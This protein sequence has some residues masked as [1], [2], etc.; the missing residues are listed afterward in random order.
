MCCHN[1]VSRRTDVQGA[2]TYTAP[3]WLL[4]TTDRKNLET[5]WVMQ[6]HRPYYRRL[7]LCLNRE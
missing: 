6:D 1:T 4:Q 3:T 2:A 5:R 7:S